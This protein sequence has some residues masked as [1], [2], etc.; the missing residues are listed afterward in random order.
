[1]T[2]RLIAA[3][4][5]ALVGAGLPIVA[6]TLQAPP[7]TR[8]APAPERLPDGKPNW[9]GFWVVPNGFMDQYRGPAGISGPAG[10]A[11][12]G[13]GGRGARNVPQRR[14]DVPE[15]KSPYKERYDALMKLAATGQPLPSGPATCLPNGMPAMMGAIYGMEILQT[16]KITAIT[17]EY[18]AVTRRIWMDKT[19]HPPAD[20][21]DDTYVGHSIGRWEGDVLVVDTVGIRTE[22]LLNGNLPH[23]N[24]L[25][26]VERIRQTAPGM[27]VDEM[28]F[29]DPDVFV[30]SWTE[31]RTYQFR[32][33]LHLQEFVCLENNRNVDEKGLPVFK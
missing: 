24:K 2:P 4:I 1:M 9:T 23:S 8:S 33:D 18:G 26:I 6:Q 11:G 17:A 21:L 14:A 19:S 16:P 10:P 28:T 3:S 29:T 7:T 31:T 22:T 20:E 15:M 27:L 5:V 30:A 32:A 13:R 25:H 12:G